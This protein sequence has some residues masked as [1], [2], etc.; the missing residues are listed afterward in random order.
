MSSGN[1]FHADRAACEKECSLNLVSNLVSNYGKTE[2]V[3]NGLLK[4]EK[5]NN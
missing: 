4:I 1:A 3:E 2:S 5:F